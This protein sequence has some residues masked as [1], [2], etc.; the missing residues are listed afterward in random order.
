MKRKLLVLIGIL[1]IVAA[2]SV[3]E[4]MLFSVDSK[5]REGT[6]TIVTSFYPMYI[7]ALNIVDGVQGVELI[8]LTENQTGC[9]HDYQITSKD[10]KKLEHADIFIMNGGGMEQFAEDILLA[11]PD[12]QVINASEGMEYLEESSHRHEGGEDHG[13]EENAHVWMNPDSYLEQVE[14]ISSGLSACDQRNEEAYE[15]NGRAYGLKI[16][17]MGKRL[18]EELGTP[19]K[20]KRK[21]I[22]FHDAFA[23]LAEYIG[24]KVVDQIEMTADSGF[25]AGKMAEI[26]D[27]IHQEKVDLLF[28]EEQFEDQIVKGIGQEAKAKVF[29]IDSLVT[30]PYDK[31]AYLNGMENNIVELKEALYEQ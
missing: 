31:D 28:M 16:E 18:K 27:E 2:I 24:L 13:E 26:I 29:L 23:Y 3:G 17:N 11:Y 6:V 14:K 25:P 10:M 30:G 4:V 8:N 7:A 1:A 9:L 21:V 22:I 5:K 20:D 19:K 12:I 15:K